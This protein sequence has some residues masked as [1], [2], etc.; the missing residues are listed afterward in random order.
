MNGCPLH[1]DIP[2][3]IKC[4]LEDDFEEAYKIISE[5][6]IMPCI[7]GRICPHDKQCRGKC[8]KGIKSNPVEIGMIEAFVRRYGY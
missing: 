6:N 8:V 5:T 1:I 3:F 7:S 4:V 2:G